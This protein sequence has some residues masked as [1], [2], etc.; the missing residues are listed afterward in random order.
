MFG[1]VERSFKDWM[2]T[3]ALMDEDIRKEY[4]TK[5]KE[6]FKKKVLELA[7]K[8][9]EYLANKKFNLLE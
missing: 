5:R 9:G 6:A 1:N 3:N 4:E 7:S 2:N 8:E